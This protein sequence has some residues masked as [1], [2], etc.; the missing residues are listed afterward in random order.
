VEGKKKEEGLI[1]AACASVHVQAGRQASVYRIVFL[2]R[3]GFFDYV[4]AYVSF[5]VCSTVFALCFLRIA[6]LTC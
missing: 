5:A 3:G 4:G 2:Q 1:G 6:S